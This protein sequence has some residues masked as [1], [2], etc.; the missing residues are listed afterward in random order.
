MGAYGT[1]T[2]GGN[3]YVER[4]QT[5]PLIVTVSNANQI[6]GSLVLPGTADFWL[7]SLTRA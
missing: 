5:F 3:T 4:E 1:V 6:R 7:K 2:I